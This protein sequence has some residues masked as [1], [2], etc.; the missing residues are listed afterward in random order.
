M[1]IFEA[2]HLEN[3]IEHK[4][5]VSEEFIVWQCVK[6]LKECIGQVMCRVH[7]VQKPIKNSEK[8][9]LFVIVIKRKIWNQF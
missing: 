5:L 2:F 8:N 7:N 6:E 1:V 9:V 3:F 4:S